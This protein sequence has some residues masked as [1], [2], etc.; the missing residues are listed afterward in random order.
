MA[1]IT[2]SRGC[3]SH[4]QEVAE[5]V[6]ARLDYQCLSR[7]VLIEA[8][9]LFHVPE[10]KLLQSLHDAP[11]FVERLTHGKEQYL[12]YV[13]AA[14][15]EVAS[16]DN[17]VYHGHGGHLLL[18]ELP[19]IL[20]VR[21]IARTEERVRLLMSR[22]GMDRKGALEWIRKEDKERSAWTRYLYGKDLKDPSLYDMVLNV[23]TLTSEDAAQL[24]CSAAGG[25]CCATTE[26]SL[27]RLKDM[28][29]QAHVTA[30]LMPLCHAEVEVDRGK[31]KVL[32]KGDK[33]RKTGYTTDSV[34]RR[35]RK[36]LQDDLNRRILETVGTLEGVKDLECKVEP[37]SYR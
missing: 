4:G 17:L 30:L 22:Q 9:R 7:E 24:I 32:V 29:L 20:K 1:V 13:R 18:P 23:G 26:Q 11:R 10:S 33:I 6:A 16:K 37:P 36:T 14:L 31:V 5:R 15:L 3:Y 25:P 35:V 21:L 34:E 19:H 12:T 2:I 28:A 8:S 27:A